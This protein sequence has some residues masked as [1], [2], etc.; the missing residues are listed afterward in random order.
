MMWQ[1]GQSEYQEGT[2]V[3]LL[4]T[5]TSTDRTGEHAHF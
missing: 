1:Q 3:N 4:C 5:N 2:W